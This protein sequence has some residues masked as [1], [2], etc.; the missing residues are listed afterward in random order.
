[1]KKKV[2]GLLV[3]AFASLIIGASSFLASTQD[4][5]KADYSPKWEAISDNGEVDVETTF[6]NGVA[7]VSI[8]KTADGFG[9][10]SIDLAEKIDYCANH[11]SGGVV[12]LSINVKTSNYVDDSNKFSFSLIFN[13]DSIIQINE[14][15]LKNGLPYFDY[16]PVETIVEFDMVSVLGSKSYADI[17]SLN[18]GVDGK[19]DV[20]F[21]ISDLKLIASHEEQQEL[22]KVLVPVNEP[23]SIYGSSFT[24]FTWG[25]SGNTI[26]KTE[27]VNEIEYSKEA[28]GGALSVSIGGEGS[29]NGRFYCTYFQ[30]SAQ[31]QQLNLNQPDG[32]SFWVYNTVIG[33]GLGFKVGT[34]IT[35]TAKYKIFD[36]NNVLIEETDRNLDYVGFRRYEVTLDE[37]ITNKEFEIFLWGASLS[38]KIYLSD[39]AFIDH[40]K[41]ENEGEETFIE[42]IVIEEDNITICSTEFISK[43]ETNEDK[44]VFTYENRGAFVRTGM[45]TNVA[46]YSDIENFTGFNIVLSGKENYSTNVIEYGLTYVDE[47]NVPAYFKLGETNAAIEGSQINI[48]I[49]NL[50]YFITYNNIQELHLYA[51]NNV[52]GEIVITIGSFDILTNIN[53]KPKTIYSYNFGDFEPGTPEPLWSLQNSSNTIVSKNIVNGGA[54]ND[55]ALAFE[56]LATNDSFSWAEVYAN[57]EKIMADYADNKLIG[58]SFW[59][60]NEQ[61]VPEGNGFWLKVG[62]VGG[63]EYEAKY[64][65]IKTDL[66][67]S[68]NLM[69]GP[70]WQKINIS[71]DPEG[72]SETPSS[73]YRPG[74]DDAT[75]F[76][77]KN[78]TAIK[79]GLWHNSQRTTRVLVD[80]FRFISDTEFVTEPVIKNYTIT[81][82]TNGGELPNDAKTIIATGEHYVLPIP[83]RNGY[84]FDGWYDNDMLLGNN[85]EEVDGTQNITL[86]AKWIKNQQPSNSDNLGLILGLSIG[87][88]VIVLSAAALTAV[89][90]IK[91]RKKQ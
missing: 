90:V 45:K 36:E 14:T 79:F 48:D 69:W 77:Y 67:T 63:H 85:I 89:L 5:A 40:V 24:S 60:Y 53:R 7:T 20:Q 62:S 87:G 49:E 29:T 73:V 17:V 61:Y 55:K 84:T 32:V 56:M 44:T 6:L 23:I 51:V 75:P 1:M 80:S 91:K 11:Y 26:T 25:G 54:V 74:S 28:D 19:D 39:F 52:L 30:M 4:V 3:L 22:E 27:V 78:I 58:I 43:I 9:G 34:E 66:G 83:T 70:G 81:Y 46:S 10:V 71:L 12:G 35:N 37:K 47:T 64:D 38:S 59:L 41:P 18:M 88:G 82:N 65:F 57:V 2:S 72:F 33:G 13:D 8:N 42:N 86:Y 31:Y 76:D 15:A 16:S 68:N 50:P 21:E